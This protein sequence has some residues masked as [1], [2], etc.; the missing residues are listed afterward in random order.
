MEDK[1]S[2]ILARKVFLVVVLFALL[3][4]GCPKAQETASPTAEER[5]EAS[6]VAKPERMPPQAVRAPAD[7]PALPAPQTTQPSVLSGETVL[8]PTVPRDA[9]MI[10]ARLAELGLYRGHVDGVWGRLS[11]AALKSFKEKNGLGDPESWNKET[12]IRL[13]RETGK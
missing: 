2:A 9:K 13:F 6:G 12:Q 5:K 3:A 10:Q 1:T 11:R 7:K 8:D 4:S